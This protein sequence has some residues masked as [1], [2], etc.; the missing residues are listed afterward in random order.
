MFYIGLITRKDYNYIQ[1][2]TEFIAT[3]VILAIIIYFLSEYKTRC[4]H[5]TKAEANRILS[6]LGKNVQY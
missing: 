1:I 6:K 5:S 4:I 3:M 2:I